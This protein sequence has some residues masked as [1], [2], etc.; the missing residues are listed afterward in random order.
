MIQEQE[1]IIHARYAF[2]NFIKFLLRKWWLFCLIGVCFG[3]IGYFYAKS[4]QLLYESN[5]T[6]VIDQDNN[7]GIS[8]AMN[9][10]SQFGINLQGGVS[11][12]VSG[13]NIIEI[14]KSRRN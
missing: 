9:I 3:A 1:E 12:I 2:L 4:Q 10:A 6:F 13:D 11:T 8:G 7:S 14:I 5:L